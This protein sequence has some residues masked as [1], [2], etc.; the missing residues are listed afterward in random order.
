MRDHRDAL[1]RLQ[2]AAADGRLGDVCERFGVLVLGAQGS[3][4]EGG[5]PAR[6]LDLAART[7]SGPLD[8][9]LDLAEALAEL[10]GGA[11]VDLM[12]L[13]RAS[14]VARTQGLSGIPLYED[15]AGRFAT[16][17]IAALSERLDTA[18]L[19]RLERQLLAS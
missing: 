8:D 19:R 18:W 7:R 4:V 9:W 11:E 5:R 3:A 10:C 12:D 13:E 1:R 16:E 6:D 2:A 17:A 15:R 14:P